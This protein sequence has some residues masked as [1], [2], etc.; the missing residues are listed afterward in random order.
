MKKSITRLLVLLLICGM[1]SGLMACGST[2][3]TEPTEEKTVIR[4]PEPVNFEK[5]TELGTPLA[6][7]RV[8]QALALAI[9]VDTV[10][11]TLYCDT[12]E[13]AALGDCSYDPEKAKDLL[14][15]A[16]WPSEYVLDVVYC[17]D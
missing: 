8:R 13:S 6:D 7:A 10:V 11:Q 14:A 1:M 5:C 15:E 17:Q 16:G 2:D 3:A 12:A 9:D 4:I